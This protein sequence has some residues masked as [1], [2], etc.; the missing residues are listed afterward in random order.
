M[1][2]Q[3]TGRVEATKGLHLMEKEDEDPERLRQDACHLAS[4]LAQS[5]EL[6]VNV[7]FICAAGYLKDSC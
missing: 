5:R 6:G 7:D 2:C 1:E 3:A 4:H